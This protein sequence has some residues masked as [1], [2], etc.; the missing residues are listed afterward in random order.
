MT[1]STAEDDGM[2]LD[3]DIM[4]DIYRGYTPAVTW[5][6]GL[7]NTPVALSG[8]VAMELLQGCANA[9]EQRRAE[10]YIRKFSLH[11]PTAADC[12]RAYQDYATFRLSH[13]LGLIDALIGATAVGLGRPLATFNVK[14]Y[15]VITGLQIVQPY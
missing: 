4:V 14:H 11:W 10:A 15:G 12:S 2:L 6:G 8:L 7:G 3:T 5:L 13:G 9:A 1:H